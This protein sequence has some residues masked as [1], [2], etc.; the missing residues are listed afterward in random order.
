MK[1]KKRKGAYVQYD[2]DKWGI[3]TKIKVDGKFLH[4]SKKGYATLSSAKAD[5]EEAKKNF[6]A[7]K[8]KEQLDLKTYNHLYHEWIEY[9]KSTSAIKTTTLKIIIHNKHINPYFMGKSVLN[10]FSLT[11]VRA[12][13]KSIIDDVRIKPLY[14]NKILAEFKLILVYAYRHKYIDAVTYQD[15]DIAVAKVKVIE[16]KK[17]KEI[18]NTEEEIKFFDYLKYYAPH[19]DYLLFQV[20]IST[21]VRASELLGIQIKNVDFNNRR[22]IINQQRVY[23]PF[24]KNKRKK[25][26]VTNRLKTNNSYRSIVISKEL[27][28]ELN[29]Y[30]KTFNLKEDDYLFDISYPVLNH[31]LNNYCSLAGVKRVSPHAFRHMQAYKLASVCVNGSDIEAAAKR[32]GHSADMFMNLYANHTQ[33][34]TEIDLV[35]R[36]SSKKG[37]NLA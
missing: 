18:W 36:L 32:L 2:D 22:I 28:N 24:S 3:D 16:Q 37:G 35:N 25:Y 21:G 14:K 19:N 34:Q 6:I 31:K 8:T 13:Y 1:V 7:L 11:N 5:F 33:E 17:E 29:E 26:I 9:I 12:W 27:C 10:A 15:V 23:N 30:V 20:L 4:F